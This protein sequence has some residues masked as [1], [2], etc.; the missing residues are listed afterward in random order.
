M[1]SGWGIVVAVNAS[2]E[3]IERRRIL[4]VR[5]TAEGGKMPFHHAE[6]LGLPKA[7]KYIAEYTDDC[8]R[9]AKQEI[10]KFLEDLRSRHWRVVKASL[11]LAS[12]KPLP[13]LAKILAAHPLIHTA[14]G[15]LFRKVVG[16]ACESFGIPVVG[17]PERRLKESAQE[18]LGQDTDIPSRLAEAGKTLGPPWTTDHKS[19]ALAAFLALKAGRARKASTK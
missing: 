18:I 11:V 17:Y 5:E 1:H 8:E 6:K 9:L 16:R 12:G 2:V 13:D 10:G 3:V 14:E 15:E 7:E 19:A 4:V